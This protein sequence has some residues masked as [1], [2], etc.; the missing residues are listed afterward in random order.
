M[1]T[2]NE[3]ILKNNKS[4][5]CRT[6]RHSNCGVINCKCNCHEEHFMVNYEL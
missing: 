2:F 1:V 6:N 5:A 3:T 4:F